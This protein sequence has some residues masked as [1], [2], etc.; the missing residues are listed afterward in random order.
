MSMCMHFEA[1]ARDLRARNL[2]L[3][4]N[5]EAQAYVARL[6]RW[7]RARERETEP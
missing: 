3:F 5:G 4:E 2:G 6:A 7:S 1:R